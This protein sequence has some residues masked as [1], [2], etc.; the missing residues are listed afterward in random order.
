[1]QQSLCSN[2]VHCVGDSVGVYVGEDVGCCVLSVKKVSFG[3]DN[4]YEEDFA[5]IILHITYRCGWRYRWVVC[6]LS[7]FIAI[8]KES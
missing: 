3:S 5:Q 6:G 1:M 4:Y 7:C 8:Q 2:T